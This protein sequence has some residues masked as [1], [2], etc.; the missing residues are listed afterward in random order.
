MPLIGPTIK[1]RKKSV[2]FNPADYIGKKY[3]HWTVLRYVG[4]IG[5]QRIFACRCKCGKVYK[6][7]LGNLKQGVSTQCHKCGA[8]AA[9][10]STRTPYYGVHSYKSVYESAKRR[11]T[12]CDEWE[13][14]VNQAVA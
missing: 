13:V 10:L 8:R 3:G 6:R 11:Y 4:M 7:H 5:C 1:T 9:G 2:P 14:N 12:L